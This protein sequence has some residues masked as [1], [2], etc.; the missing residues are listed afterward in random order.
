M[1]DQPSF[2]G[3]IWRTAASS[4][5]FTAAL[6]GAA[7][8]LTS[9]LV[10]SGERRRDVLRQIVLG[11]LTA[12]GLGSASGAVIWHWLD[13]PMGAIPMAGVGGGASYLTGV[14]GPAFF[15]VILTRLRLRLPPK[16]GE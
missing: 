14:F 7:G 11:M 12:A 9:A 10:I 16:G 3:E 2:W 6:W 13:L 8:G 4:A 1:S 15:E 5:L